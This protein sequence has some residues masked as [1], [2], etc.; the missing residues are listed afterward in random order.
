[1]KN[2]ENNTERLLTALVFENH[3]YIDLTINIGKLGLL[4]TKYILN[5]MK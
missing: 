1:M 4:L 2:K 3:S 5:P